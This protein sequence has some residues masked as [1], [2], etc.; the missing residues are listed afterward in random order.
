MMIFDT[1]DDVIG[2]RYNLTESRRTINL[3]GFVLDSTTG[4]GEP[5]L[6]NIFAMGKLASKR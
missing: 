2:H 3:M 4:I 6:E 5:K 1:E